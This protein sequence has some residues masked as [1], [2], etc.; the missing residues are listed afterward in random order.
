MSGS[1]LEFHAGRGGACY[2]F[3]IP[4]LPRAHPASAMSGPFGER[5]EGPAPLMDVRGPRTIRFPKL[6]YHPVG[7]CALAVLAALLGDLAS[8]L[9]P[10]LPSFW[11]RFLSDFDYVAIVV[12]GI[13]FGPKGGL[14][15]AAVSG[16]SHTA[17]QG[18]GFNH[19]LAAQGELTVFILVGLL[20]GF[21]AERRPDSSSLGWQTDRSSSE[22]VRRMHFPTPWQQVAPGLVHQLR[23]PLASIQGAA[24]VLEDDSLPADRRRELIGIVLKECQRLDL[25]IGLMDSNHS[26]RTEHTTVDIGSLLDEVTQRAVETLHA[27]RV[28]IEKDVALNLPPV[29]LDREAIAEAILDVLLDAIKA[30]PEGGRIFL[31]CRAVHDEILIQ[32]SDERPHASANRVYR[33]LNSAPMGCWPEIELAVAQRIL[34]RQ[35]GALRIDQNGDSGLIFTLILPNAPGAHA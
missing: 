11:A 9:W 30:T 19:P 20:A 26:R 8:L 31:A 15:T 28:L 35:G 12:G 7:I 21:F 13:Y 2:D 23:T 3:L 22:P 24:F 4:G 6:S 16:I 17:I 27:P 5:A 18:L 32:V 25:F 34:V 33:A 14:I 29:R 10:G 1:E